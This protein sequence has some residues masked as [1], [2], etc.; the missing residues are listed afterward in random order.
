M[1]ERSS[2][3]PGGKKRSKKA[4][5]DVGEEPAEKDPEAAEDGEAGESSDE[6]SEPADKDV[7]VDPDLIEA[8]SEITE[9]ENVDDLEDVPEPK[10]ST[11]GGSLARRD[12]MAAYMVTESDAPGG[13]LIQG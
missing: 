8:A 5:I 7:E 1:A 12:P 10:V 11:R 9:A 2:K 13:R 6:D 3:P 4:V